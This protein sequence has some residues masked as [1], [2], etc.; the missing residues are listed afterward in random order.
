MLKNLQEVGDQTLCKNES[1]WHFRPISR[2]SDY[3]SSKNETRQLNMR[4]KENNR[5]CCWE[6]QEVIIIIETEIR[7]KQRAGEVRRKFPNCAN[8]DLPD[9]SIPWQLDAYQFAKGLCK[10]KATDHIKKKIIKKKANILIEKKNQNW[11]LNLTLYFTDF[12]FHECRGSFHQ[13]KL[14]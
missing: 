7:I 8:T 6:T 14:S 10:A 11:V 1:R 3:M 9:V 2:N 5:K 13:T 12:K 4:P